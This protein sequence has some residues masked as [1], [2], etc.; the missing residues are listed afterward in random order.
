MPLR[1][2]PDPPKPAYSVKPPCLDADHS[3]PGM[4]VLEPGTYEH[5]CPRCGDVTV[6]VVN[7]SWCRTA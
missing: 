4:I 2:L 7:V 3:P 5:R 6:F 1:R